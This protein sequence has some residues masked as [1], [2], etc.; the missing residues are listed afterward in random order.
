MIRPGIP[1]LGLV[2]ALC[3]TLAGCASGSIWSGASAPEPQ[4][5]S[6][7]DFADRGPFD[8]T[9]NRSLYNGQ[10]GPL[11]LLDGEQ[12]A[13]EESD[14]LE[15][16]RRFVIGGIARRAGASSSDLTTGRRLKGHE[17]DNLRLVRL[18]RCDLSHTNFGRAGAGGL[19]LFFTKD[20]EG[21]LPEQVWETRPNPCI[22]A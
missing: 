11:V 15:T 7:L 4:Q 18:A 5:V 3:S 22:N 8:V 6:I 21:P 12:V 19:I 10:N 2:L 20:W 13:L 14:E 16:V 17:F 1:A 9:L